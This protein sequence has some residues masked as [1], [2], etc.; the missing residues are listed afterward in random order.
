MPTEKTKKI[1]KGLYPNCGH[2]VW[3]YLDGFIKLKCKNCNLVV[4]ISGGE[5]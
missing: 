3:E 5:E 2:N 4:I 1:D